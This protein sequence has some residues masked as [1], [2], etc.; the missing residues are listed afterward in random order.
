MGPQPCTQHW[1]GGPSPWKDETAELCFLPLP[2]RS[3]LPRSR[4]SPPLLCPSSS[5]HH[6]SKTFRPAEPG[7]GVPSRGPSTDTRPPA[8]SRAPRANN[9]STELN[10]GGGCS[11]IP[12]SAGTYTQNLEGSRP[13]PVG[14][15]PPVTNDVVV[16]NVRYG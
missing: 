11:Y 1:P 6:E 8:T 13:T 15:R 14:C 2:Q 9:P 5:T 10:D 7:V 3:L 16:W 4:R 12:Q